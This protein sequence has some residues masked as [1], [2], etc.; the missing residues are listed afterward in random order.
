MSTRL[1]SE[2]RPDIP[3][4]HRTLVVALREGLEGSGK[5]LRQVALHA[6][7]SPAAV[8]HTLNG[9]R[10]PTPGVFSNLVRGI[11][12]DAQRD[13]WLTLYAAAS[14]SVA[15]A[16]DHRRRARRLALGTAIALAVVGSISPALY[17]YAAEK[18]G[19]AREQQELNAAWCTVVRCQDL[20]TVPERPAA[21][22]GTAGNGRVGARM[23]PF[24]DS[25]GVFE[26]LRPSESVKVLCWAPGPRMTLRYLAVTEHGDAGYLD[27]QEVRFKERVSVGAC[28][29]NPDLK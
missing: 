13:P 3:K 28:P 10:F 11:G 16:A 12:G 9:A 2:I 27:S 23:Y 29:R 18:Y 19:E 25:V 22:A 24:S 15:S 8:C 26:V 7:V 6:H 5:S 4:D 1:R 17:E 14:V 20:D 21:V